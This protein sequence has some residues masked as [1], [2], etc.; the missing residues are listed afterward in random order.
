MVNL[1]LIL[2]TKHH[3]TDPALQIMTQ[4]AFEA[5]LICRYEFLSSLKCSSLSEIDKN[6][7]VKNVY[8]NFR[9]LADPVD[10]NEGCLRNTY[11]R[12]KFYGEHF[13]M[14]P[15]IQIPLL[16][17]DGVESGF[18]Y[19]YIPVLETLTSMLRNEHIRHFCEKPPPCRDSKGLFDVVDE[20][21]VKTNKLLQVSKYIIHVLLYQ[22]AF[23]IC[24]PLG[25]SKKKCK[26]IA[27]YMM[28]LNVPPYLRIKRDNIKLVLLC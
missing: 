2:P 26:I 18:Y 9:G 1:C 24:N 10:E 28:L 11:Q 16:Y 12:M 20:T 7:V 25:A 5:S 13:H 23:E 4:K 3:T 15:S 8:S 6:F 17:E 14:V 27:L 19:S 21:L 22:D